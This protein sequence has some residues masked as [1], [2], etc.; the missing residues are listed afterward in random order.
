[1]SLCFNCLEIWSGSCFTDPP[2]FSQPDVPEEQTLRNSSI[3]QKLVAPY[4]GVGK[5][6]S[7]LS[8][9]FL[10]CFFFRPIAGLEQGHNL[11]KWW[12][13]VSFWSPQRLLHCPKCSP[14]CSRGDKSEGGDELT[15]SVGM[16]WFPKYV[17][18]AA[19]QFSRLKAFPLKRDF[20]SV[21]KTSGESIPSIQKQLWHSGIA[22]PAAPD[23][24]IITPLLSASTSTLHKTWNEISWAW[25]SLWF[26]PQPMEHLRNKRENGFLSILHSLR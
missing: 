2:P 23:T 5:K 8:I 19:Q 15:S 18:E 17:C 11:G 26:T 20:R 4:P 7:K 9:S 21:A 10:L 3:P 1:M 12:N 24:Q 13:S 14:K 6:A 25:N 22:S 16:F